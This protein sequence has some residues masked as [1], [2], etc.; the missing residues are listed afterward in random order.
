MTSLSLDSLIISHRRFSAD[1]SDSDDRAWIVALD[2]GMAHATVGRS[3]RRR[4]NL[5]SEQVDTF[6]ISR[7]RR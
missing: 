3:I 2:I 6:L 4:I 7:R 5:V 1:I